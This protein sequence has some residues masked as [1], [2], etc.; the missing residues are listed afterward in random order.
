MLRRRS[1]VN[2]ML[3]TV[4]FKIQPFPQQFIGSS[5]VF[6][7]RRIRIPCT[8]GD[9][10]FKSMYRTGNVEQKRKTNKTA[11]AHRAPSLS[12]QTK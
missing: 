6:A 3:L 12:W 7:R 4:S 5:A 8:A 2:M 11:P 1:A 9:Y 10:A